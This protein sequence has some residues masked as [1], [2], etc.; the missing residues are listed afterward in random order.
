MDQIKQKT[1]LDDETINKI[2]DRL[3]RGGIIV[4]SQSR[5]TGIHIY[6]LMGPYPGMFEFTMMKGEIDEHHKK[7]AIIFEEL[8]N[9]M[10]DKIQENYDDVTKQ[11]NVKTFPAVTRTVPVEQEIDPGQEHILTSEE[12]TKLVDDYEDIGLAHCYCRHEKDLANDPCKVTN[13]RENCIVLGKGAKFMIEYNFANPISKEQA[14]KILQHA[15]DEGLV[16]K[17][18]HVHLDP[19]KEIE[20]I[21]SCCKCC[22]GIFR[23][24]YKGITPHHTTT[25]YIAEVNEEDCIGC[26]TCEEKCPMEAIELEDFIAR[27]DTNKCIGCGVCVHLCPEK[28]LNLKHTELRDVFVLPP[29][30]KS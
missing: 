6:R 27:I 21:C 3:M 12:V 1:D 19:S 8:F 16:H 10:S 29:K 28:A 13:E 9:E 17:V 18:F 5:T 26:G 22:C 24:Y 20:G 4:R 30:L 7:L 15:E 25:N 14:K 11:F 23:F 2:L